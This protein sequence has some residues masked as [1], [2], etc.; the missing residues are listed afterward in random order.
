MKS[1]LIV[2]E[3]SFTRNVFAQ[4]LSS[5]GF[6]V[7]HAE[8]RNEAVATL[9]DHVMDLIVTGLHETEGAELVRILRKTDLAC[10]IVMLSSVFRANTAEY[11][12]LIEDLDISL[13]LHKPISP[14]EFCAQIETVFDLSVET[15][16]LPGEGDQ[17][18]EAEDARLAYRDTV[19]LQLERLEDALEKLRNHPT[20]DFSGPREA[21]AQLRAGAS[22]HGFFAVTRAAG[23]IEAALLTIAMRGG[24]RAGWAEVHD[25]MD[26]AYLAARA[27]STTELEPDDITTVLVVD[28]DPQFLRSVERFGHEALIRVVAAQSADEVVD[29]LRDPMIEALL[30]DVDLGEGFDTFE[31]VRELRERSSAQRLPL[32]FLADRGTLPDR[33]MAA[34]LGASVFVE[35]PADGA[36]FADIVQRLVSARSAGEEPLVAVIDRDARFVSEVAEMLTDAGMRSVHVASTGE[37]V[38]SIDEIAP[39]GLIVNVSMPGIGGFDLCRMVRAMPRWH[40]LPILLVGDRMDPRTRIAAFRSGA[41]DYLSKPPIREELL[42][43]LE[44]R[45]E[46]LRL[47]REQA[48]RDLLTG[49]LNRRPFLQRI[50]ARLSEARRSGRELALALLDLDGFKQVNDVHGHMTGDRVLAAL[51]RLLTNRFRM[52]DLRGRWGGEE[53]VVAL[54]GEEAHTASGVLERTLDEFRAMTFVGENGHHFNVTFSAGVAMFPSDSDN[55]RGL[56]SVADTRLYAAKSRGKNCI[57][58]TDPEPS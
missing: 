12:E 49:L 46:R 37:L 36:Q 32:G 18:T 14:V 53:F 40:E 38:E 1:V 17:I 13:V 19:E 55:F 33:V 52:E 42:A 27:R 3:D 54:I 58:A 43:R 41:D 45:I 10:R 34:H 9:S 21:A 4:T 47:L 16:W 35:K 50:N 2:D 30:V 51:G 31:F 6:E 25:A 15:K 22:Q 28:D 56:L 48:S 7:F 26:D 23:H 8:S 39:D 44:V 5:R 29:R 24:D 20:P 57:V 11:D